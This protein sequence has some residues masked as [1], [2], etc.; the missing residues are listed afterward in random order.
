MLGTEYVIGFVIAI[1]EIIKTI[2]FLKTNIGKLIV[3]ILV[4]FMSGIIQVLNAWVFGGMDL[5]L[6]F[7]GGLELGAV[8]GGL[9]SMG[10]TYLSKTNKNGGDIG[11]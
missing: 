4:F 10:Q 2:P 7:K 5:L 3:P 8:S 6:A 1:I 11:A 9:Y